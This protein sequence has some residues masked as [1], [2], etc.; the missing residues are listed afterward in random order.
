MQQQEQGLEAVQRVFRIRRGCK[1][2]AACLLVHP[3]ALGAAYH[4]W[5][6]EARDQTAF[7]VQKQQR[8]AGQSLTSEGSSVELRDESGQPR[9]EEPQAATNLLQADPFPLFPGLQPQTDSA[10]QRSR[11]LHHAA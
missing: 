5:V 3:H 1:Q 10:M 8:D 2:P 4:A 11:R 6:A 7:A 9:H